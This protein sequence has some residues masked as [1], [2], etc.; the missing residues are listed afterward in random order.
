MDSKCSNCRKTRKVTVI[1]EVRTGGG[2]IVMRHQ[3][4]AECLKASRRS[5]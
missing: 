1:E 5:A 4:C 2:K 3:L